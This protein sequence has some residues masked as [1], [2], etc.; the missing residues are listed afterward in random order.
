MPKSPAPLASTLLA[1]VTS[2]ILIASTLVHCVPLFALALLKFLIPVPAVRTRLT[3]ALIV[4]AESW[5][6]V[7]STALAWLTPLEFHVEG[8]ADLAYKGHYLVISNHQSWVDIPVLQRTFNKR[9]PFL[10]FFLKKELIWV[11]VLGLAWWALDFPFMKRHSRELLARHPELQGSDLATTRKACE[12]FRL[13]PVSVMNFLEGTRFTDERRKAQDSP[14]HH[15]LRAKAG[16]IAF[17]LGA[18]G[19]VLGSM[20]DVTIVYPEGQPTMVDLLGGRVGRVDVLIREREIP[21]ELCG[22]DYENDAEFRERFQAWV[23]QLWLEKDELLRERLA[24]S[25]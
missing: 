20:L 23:G 17:V 19:D 4:V 16:G 2:S 3:R 11:P 7:N 21:P 12:K 9:I 8:D 1:V 13:V 24:A 18:M 14:Y 6:S 22:G 25:R 15:L 5:I 10:K